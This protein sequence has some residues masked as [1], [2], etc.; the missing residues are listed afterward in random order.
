[1]SLSVGSQSLHWNRDS[2]YSERQKNEGRR[3]K[4]DCCY[5]AVSA[6][7]SLLTQLATA[8]L[9]CFSSRHL[10]KIRLILQNQAPVNLS[11]IENQINENVDPRS[12]ASYLET[13]ICVRE[14]SLSV[15]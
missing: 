11:L 13:K 9:N 10:N 3:Q 5:A 15:S 8:I 12:A 2:V 4:V 6:I 7:Q 1:M 14:I